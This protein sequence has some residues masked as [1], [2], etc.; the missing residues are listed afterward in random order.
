MSANKE[1]DRI[2][3]SQ[4]H[5]VTT[6]APARDVSKRYRFIPTSEILSAFEGS[7]WYP[8]SV[9]EKMCRK[10]QYE[11]FQKHIVR[12]RKGSF[13][14]QGV[15]IA[16]PEI[17]ITNSHDRSSCFKIMMGLWRQVCTNGMIVS[18]GAFASFS[19]KHIGYDD[20]R[21]REA[22]ERIEESVDPVL[23]LV[24]T[25]Q[26]IQLTETEMYNYA[27]AAGT[28]RWDDVRKHIPLEVL[29]AAKRP[30]DKG[31][32]LWHVFNRVQE[33]MTNGH[34][35]PF[36]K[37]SIKALK[38]VD[39]IVSVNRSLWSLTEMIANDKKAVV[40]G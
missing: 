32:S 40:V 31:N 24:I 3:I 5:S 34:R 20:E 17:V 13:G 7:G 8:S 30:E 25:F 16:F 15:G 2:D 35:D 12:L 1:L 29:V 18:D 21:V 23:G 14:P 10:P 26:E 11:G 27:A 9:Q 38:S 33:K 36:N 22:V 4:F 19:I 6:R 39:Q 28:F 37:I